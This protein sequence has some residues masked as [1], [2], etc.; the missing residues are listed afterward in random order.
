[1]A[2][3]PAGLQ[4]AK[5]FAYGLVAFLAFRDVVQSQAGNHNIVMI[6]GVD[7]LTRIA[8]IDAN[9]ISD[10]FEFCV[11]L[12]GIGEFPERIVGTPYVDAGRPCPFFRR[13]AA[14]IA[15]SPRPQPTSSTC[16]SPRSVS[17]SRIWSRSRS[18]ATRLDHTITAPMARN[19]RP[20]SASTPHMRAAGPGYSA[21]VDE[22]D[23]QRDRQ[24]PGGAAEHAADDARR[25]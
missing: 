24:G 5:H 8:A 1:M 21:A 3:W 7:Q 16:S 23:H 4:N 15:S 6:V 20:I 18:L 10:A 13:L 2:S 17:E 14:P 11:R 19:T 22:I 9:L 12:G 25:V